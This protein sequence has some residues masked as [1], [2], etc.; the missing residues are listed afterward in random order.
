MKKGIYESVINHELEEELKAAKADNLQIEKVDL[1][2]TD[3]SKLLSSFLKDKID[4]ALSDKKLNQQVTLVNDILAKLDD[5][6]SITIPENNPK[7]LLSIYPKIKNSPVRPET[8]VAFSS[9]FTG[10]NGPSLQEEMNREIASADS[11][12]FLVSFI[13]WSGL[14]I[15]LPALTTAVNRG[16]KL[17]IITTSYMGATD[18]RAIEELSK[19]P[20]TE[21]RISYDTKRTRLHAKTYVFKRDTD[22]T[23]AYVGSSNMSSAALSS[24]LEWNLKIAKKELPETM[25][26]IEKTFETYWAQAEF[27]PY[28]E[29]DADRLKKDLKAERHHDNEELFYAFDIQP[30]SF[31]KEILENLDAERNVHGHDRNLLVA[32]TGTGK[33]IIAALDYRDWRKKHPT[34]RLLFIAHREEILKQSI[35][36]FRAVLKNND[37]GSLVVGNRETDDLSHLFI[38]IQSVRSKHLIK[39]VSPTYYDYIII[40]EFHHAAADSYQE[41]LDYF[42]PKTLLGLTATPE[43][44]DGL[45]VLSYFDGRIAAELRLP[46]AIDRKLLCPFQY[47]GIADD[48]DLSKIKWTRGGYDEK[49]LS[50]LFTISHGYA[51]R[52]ADLVINS[53]LRYVTDINDV[54]GLGFCVSKAHARFMA[55]RFSERG[56]PSMALTSDSTSE[57]RN[58]AELMLVRKEIHFLFTVDIYNEGVDIPEVNTVLFLRPTK[59][60]TIFLQQ[61]GRGLRL[62]EGKDVLTILDFIGQA[63]EKYNF[64]EKFRA[65]VKDKT[66]PIDKEIKNNFSTLPAGCYIQLQKQAQ[67]YILKNIRDALRNQNAL[68]EKIKYFEEDTDKE[69][70]LTNFLDTYPDARKSIYTKTTF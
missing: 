16:V 1:T 14:R 40:D 64:E 8:S 48:T 52:R 62:C 13:K 15:L 29:A 31:Q 69:L 42:K 28:T 50:D 33:T 11:I 56:I 55:E 4:E 65:L 45:D 44:M 9:L 25:D 22:F 24:G 10:S 5:D 23:T 21:I 17:R 27:E 32:A 63:N 54:I 26:Q 49:E 18:F 41:V 67:E 30:Y 68:K 60:L 43:R 36:A 39:E 2:K 37:F 59:S 47:F 38:S 66:R 34:D 61:L 53:T 6:E 3:S 46:E 19:L 7:E 35:S 70:T 12:D 20:N 51:N 58:N 57:D